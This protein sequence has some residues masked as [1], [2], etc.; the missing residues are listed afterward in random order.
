MC[1]CDTLSRYYSHLLGEQRAHRRVSSVA[2]KE[3]EEEATSSRLYRAT[4]SH[5]VEHDWISFLFLLHQ[6]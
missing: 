6:A 1:T 4:L 2:A 5:C 3:E